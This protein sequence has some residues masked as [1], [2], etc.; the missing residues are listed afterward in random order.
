MG[1]PI[2]SRSQAKPRHLI[3]PV[4]AAHA[5]TTAVR[6][7]RH[8]E[9]CQWHEYRHTRTR[10][11][12]ERKRRDSDGKVHVEKIKETGARPRQATSDRDPS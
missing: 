2:A 3:V 9:Y 1:C 4:R 5:A 12:G 10:V 11:V 6:Y 8:A 7:T